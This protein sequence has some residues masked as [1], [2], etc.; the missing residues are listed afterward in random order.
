M[1]KKGFGAYKN[2]ALISQIGLE[3]II[4]IIASVWIGKKLMDWFHW[5]PVT[6]LV[7]I[8]IGVVTAFL[9]LFRRALRQSQRK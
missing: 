3:M 6:L 4:P 9:N 1:F 5:G 7:C 8:L 2:I